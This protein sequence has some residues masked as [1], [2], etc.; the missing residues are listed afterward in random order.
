MRGSGRRCETARGAAHK[1]RSGAP[2]L[3]LA[4][5][6]G[7]CASEGRLGPYFDGLDPDAGPARGVFY[8]SAVERGASPVPRGSHEP[9]VV[10]QSVFNRINLHRA[11]RGLSPLRHHA[12]LAEVAGHHARRMAAGAPMSHDGMRGRLGPFLGG[13]FGYRG[14]GEILASTSP[15]GDPA[16]AAMATWLASYRHRDVIEEDYSRI[17]IGVARRPSG[18]YYFAVLF[19]R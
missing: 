8:A 17:G 10:Q 11:T 4:L 9:A 13:V 1:A 3:F 5:G 18:G 12:Q 16:A 2:L 15:A 14:G 19:L 7:G 6:L